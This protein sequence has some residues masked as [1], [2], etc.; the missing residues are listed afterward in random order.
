MYQAIQS[1]PSC[2]H[3]ISGE[4]GLQG[5]CSTAEVTFKR[6]VDRGSSHIFTG[7]S[8]FTYFSRRCLEPTAPKRAAHD[9]S[10]TQMKF[11]PGRLPGYLGAFGHY[12]YGD[13]PVREHCETAEAAVVTFA[14]DRL[15]RW[16]TDL[17]MARRVAGD[18]LARYRALRLSGVCPQAIASSRPDAFRAWM[19]HVYGVTRKRRAWRRL[20][21][22]Y[23]EACFATCAEL[24]AQVLQATATEEGAIVPLR[25]VS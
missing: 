8:G 19:A 1:S 20:W 6:D 3:E 10:A 5:I 24:D 22:D 9:V 18:V 13:C 14:H 21:A 25:R 15:E 11:L 12:L 16:P 2:P 7:E 17:A 4:V 23:V